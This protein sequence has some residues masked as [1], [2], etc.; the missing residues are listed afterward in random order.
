MKTKYKKI[1]I[2]IF[3]LIAILL[4]GMIV[5]WFRSQQ[6]DEAEPL[7][8]KTPIQLTA[9]QKE[10]KVLD[11]AKA[12]SPEQAQD[13]K[14][15]S[16]KQ[17]KNNEIEYILENTVTGLIETYVIEEDGSVYLEIKTHMATGEGNQ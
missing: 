10:E 16:Q 9:K 5:V 11:T 15:V 4:I 7:P 17:R 12:N 13:Y 8:T 1:I 3:V 2:L 6:I 14:I